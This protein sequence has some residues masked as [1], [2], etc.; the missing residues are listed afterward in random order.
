MINLDECKSIGTHW[1]AFCVNGDKGSMSQDVTYFDNFGVNHIPK[2]IKKIRGNKSI[3]A[4]ICR[5][6]E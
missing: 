1:K 5:V 4:D 3:T 6:Q 2:E